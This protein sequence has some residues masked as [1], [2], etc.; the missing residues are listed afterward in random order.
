MPMSLLGFNAPNL[1]YRSKKLDSYM[2]F[3]K[4][5]VFYTMFKVYTVRTFTVHPSLG[6]PVLNVKYMKSRKCHMMF[7]E[8]PIQM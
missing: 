2:I 7:W 1:G 4:Y 6:F 5:V 3:S 8:S